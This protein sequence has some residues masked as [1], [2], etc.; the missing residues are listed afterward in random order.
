MGE[1]AAASSCLWECVWHRMLGTVLCCQS[2]I[3][4]SE[5]WEQLHLHNVAIGAQ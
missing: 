3:Y 5:E 4:S 1:E 2:L